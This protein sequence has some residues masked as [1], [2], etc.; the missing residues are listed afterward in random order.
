[1]STDFITGTYNPDVLSC[2]ANLSS[3]EV[4]TPPEIANKILDM[5]PQEIFCNPNTTFLDPACKSGVFL[6]EI[7][8]R[9]IDG[10][11]NEIPNLE[12]RIHHILHKQVFGIA[13]T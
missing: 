13:V 9:L 10:L 11:E 2:I 3:D 7:T 12:E 8:K 6:R 4:F 5:L 1:M